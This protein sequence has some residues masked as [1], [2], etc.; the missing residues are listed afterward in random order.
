MNHDELTH[1]LEQ[2]IASEADTGYQA[3]GS[4]HLGFVS[5]KLLSAEKR[6]VGQHMEVTYAYAVFVE[7][8]FSTWEYRHT[9]RLLLTAQMDVL[10]E[11]VLASETITH[12]DDPLGHIEGDW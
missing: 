4:G 1:W 9:K 7:S 12:R 3:G 6:P 11:D 2:R 10:A 8:E 5:T